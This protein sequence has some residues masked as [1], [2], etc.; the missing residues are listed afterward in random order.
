MINELYHADNI[1][2]FLRYSIQMEHYTV[3]QIISLLL[4]TDMYQTIK[5]KKE[6][7]VH[8][9]WKIKDGNIEAHPILESHIANF[10]EKMQYKYDIT[11]LKKDYDL[12][13]HL[14]NDTSTLKDFTN[15]LKEDKMNF[16]MLIDLTKNHSF[17]MSDYYGKTHE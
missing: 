12:S 9:K 3:T 5:T 16:P 17:T 13:C 10:K 2:Y 8:L 15:V 11:M 1:L 4:L 7:F 14:I 6:L